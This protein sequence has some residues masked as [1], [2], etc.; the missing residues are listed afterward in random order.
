MCFGLTLHSSNHNKIEK[1][2]FLH[3]QEP[4]PGQSYAAFAYREAKALKSML[5][6]DQIT[7]YHFTNYGKSSQNKK[8]IGKYL[9]WIHW[10]VDFLFFLTSTLSRSFRAPHLFWYVGLVLHRGHFTFSRPQ[11][12]H[13]MQPL[14]DFEEYES[15]TEWREDEKLLPRSSEPPVPTYFMRN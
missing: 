10:V 13:G 2:Q 6:G 7:A 5:V 1:C 3:Y 12:G 14:S 8:S 4:G 15:W 9:S 11:G